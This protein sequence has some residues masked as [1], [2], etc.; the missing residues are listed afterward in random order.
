MDW[1]RKLFGR[2]RRPLESVPSPVIA[3]DKQRTLAKQ[4]RDV[5]KGEPG[6]VVPMDEFAAAFNRTLGAVEENVGR[7][8]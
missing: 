2:K 6:E 3:F 5:W 8:E 7:D 1:L 4:R